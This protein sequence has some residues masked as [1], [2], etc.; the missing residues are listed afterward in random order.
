MFYS[1]KIKKIKKNFKVLEVGPGNSPFYRSDILLEKQFSEEEFDRQIGLARDNKSTKQII[2][3]TG[4]IFPFDDNEFDYVICSHV[5]EHIPIEQ[6][7][8]FISELTRVAKMGY[9]EIPLYSYELLYDSDVHL[10]YI[11]VDIDNKLYFLDKQTHNQSIIYENL[12]EILYNSLLI[13]KIVKNNEELFI[14]GF[15]WEETIAFEKIE[16]F[17]KL[18]TKNEIDFSNISISQSYLKNILKRLNVTRFKQAIY[19]RFN[20]MV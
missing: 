20:I 2:Y 5:L 11:N 6:L 1:H 8:I 13:G 14:K 9:I 15:E 19:N 7:S 16:T 17:Y 18:K 12:K 3:Y 4:D 10:S